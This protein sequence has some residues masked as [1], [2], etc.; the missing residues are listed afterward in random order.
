MIILI[1]FYCKHLHK[2]KIV[3][4]IATFFTLLYITKEKKQE[5]KNEKSKNDEEICC[6][7][8]QYWY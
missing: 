2:F 3:D 6:F 8:S 5:I 4:F 1:N 7:N